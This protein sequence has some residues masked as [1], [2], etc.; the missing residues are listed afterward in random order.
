MSLNEFLEFAISV[1]AALV[2]IHKKDHIYGNI[3]PDNIIWKSEN[4]TAE[5]VN[6]S[7]SDEKSLFSAASLPYIS[8]EQTGRMNRR[9]DYRTDLYSLGIVFYEMLVGEPP[10][11]EDEIM[12]KIFDPFFTTK[13]IGEGVG[14]GLS[15]S[16]GIIENHGG[17]F[18][19]IS[20]EGEGSEFTLPLPM[21]IWK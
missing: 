9:V 17:S 6:P 11:V 8:P 4:L 18:G 3:C 14:L 13:K 5:L 7:E 12:E 19:V 21:K 1:S 2:D 20:K 10:F 16:Y 15:I